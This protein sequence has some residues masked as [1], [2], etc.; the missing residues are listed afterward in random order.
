MYARRDVQLQEFLQQHDSQLPLP[1]AAGEDTIFEYVVGDKGTWEHWQ[2]RV[3]DRACYLI[4]LEFHGTS[5]P[6]SILEDPRKD[7]NV[8]NKSCVSCSYG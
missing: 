7:T 1:A 6:R 5:F 4:K 3:T 8:R 2:S